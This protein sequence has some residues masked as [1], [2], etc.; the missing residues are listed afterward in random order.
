MTSTRARRLAAGATT[1][2]LAAALLAPAAIAFADEA[3]SEDQT[4]TVLEAPA[5]DTPAPAGTPD[6]PEDLVGD[7]PVDAEPADEPSEAPAPARAADAAPAPAVRASGAE[8]AAPGRLFAPTIA[9]GGTWSTTVEVDDALALS[10]VVLGTS[11]SGDLR[12]PGG[13]TVGL[14][15]R[16]GGFSVGYSLSA[17]PQTGTV[18]IN[19][20]N[21]AA[22][23]RTIRVGVTYRNDTVDLGMF[24]SGSGS[25][26]LGVSVNP[27]ENGTSRT[28]VT[29]QARLVAADGTEL[30]AAMGPIVSGSSQRVARFTDMP[31][32]PY[33]AFAT[34]TIDGEEFSGVI[35]VHA[36]APETT[37]PAVGYTTNPAAS[38]SR[39]WFARNVT[40][41][42]AASDAGAGVWRM[43]HSLD[44]A[45][46]S[47][48]YGEY[49]SLV[50]GEGEHELRYYA[51]DLQN[52]VSDVVTRTIRVDVTPPTIDLESLPEE[53][54][55][56]ED[57]E[58]SY[59]CDDALS[60]IVGCTAPVSSGERLD[61][62]TPGVHEFRVIATD[63][64]GNVTTE[65][66]SY[67]V[68]SDDT[69]GPE[70]E[71]AVPEE[72]ASGWHTRPVTLTFTASDEE[73]GIS[74]IRWEYATGSGV[75]IGSTTEETGSLE[76]A[77]T[78]IYRVLVW[79][80]DGAG[81][82]TEA[83]AVTVRVDLDAPLVEVTSPEDPVAA[84]L[85]N[86]H[87]AQ[88]ERVVVRFACSDRGSGVDVCDATTPDGE[89]LPTGTP[90]THELRIV[91]TDVAGN[92]T[93]RVISYTVDAAATPTASRDPRLAQT[94]A[95]FVI[96]GIALVAVLL[97]AGATLL[98][99][100]RLGGR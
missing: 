69:T 47:T 32:G 93:E 6:L 46:Y 98:A 79:A 12:T 65:T 72:P 63:A 68:L 33:L 71:V 61:T 44:G 5:G 81:N 17:T 58:V 80:E 16:A 76:L 42:L 13:T 54:E 30:T 11:V 60:G 100:R 24:T 36:A 2:L 48:V 59:S 88:H 75:V 1:A 21:D 35:G 62:S 45:E 39:G 78:G 77:A 38:N 74:R 57:V 20:R 34:V 49:H 52:N 29:A 82:R 51:E 25:S 66:R 87:Y 10:V 73:S 23:E 55:V 67:R 31:S 40:V 19:V 86:G 37:P 50:V 53:V 43:F 91:A 70:L 27:T 64:A 92:R 83:D 3:P 7:T 97:A 94:G 4:T 95:E 84:I 28:D 26:Q 96:P 99:S 90:G 15:P 8:L 22:T 41:S 18:T 14:S 56:D 85:P 9:A 89:L